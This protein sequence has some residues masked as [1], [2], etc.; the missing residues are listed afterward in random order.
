VGLD[1][2]ASQYRYDACGRTI[3]RTFAAGH[4]RPSPAFAW[5]ASGQLVARTTPEGQTRYHYTPSGLLSRIGL[6]PALAADA[7]TTAAEQEL[8]LS[9][10]RLVA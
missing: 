10:T 2:V 7:W 1:G 9:M 3:A 4:P 6:H 5:S 8:A